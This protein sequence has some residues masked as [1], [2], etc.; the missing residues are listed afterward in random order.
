MGLGQNDVVLG[1]QLFFFKLCLYRNNVVLDCFDPKRRRFES[2][3]T[4]PKRRRFISSRDKTTSFYLV[5]V[6]S[7]AHGGEDR[8]AEPAAA[9]QGFQSHLMLELATAAGDWGFGATSDRQTANDDC[10][11]AK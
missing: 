3:F 5:P 1:L 7:K 8:G 4:Y 11:S 6:C 10:D 2:A 9:G